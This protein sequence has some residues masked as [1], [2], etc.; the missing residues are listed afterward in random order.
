MEKADYDKAIQCLEFAIECRSAP[1]DN[2][3]QAKIDEC[4]RL[5]A[6]ADVLNGFVVKD[7]QF[8]AADS[9]GVLTGTYGDTLRAEDVKQLLIRLE[10]STEQPFR[11]DMTIDV[12]LSDPLGQLLG[13]SGGYTYSSPATITPLDS[14]ADLQPYGNASDTFG[15][16]R[17]RCEVWCRDSLFFET[18]FTLVPRAV[19][20]G[21]DES[22]NHTPVTPSVADETSLTTPVAPPADRK[23]MAELL[24]VRASAGLGLVM[25]SFAC[26]QGGLG[27]GLDIHVGS[28]FTVGPYAELAGT[29]SLLQGG[30]PYGSVGLEGRVYFSPSYPSLYVDVQGGMAFGEI[31]RATVLQP[32]WKQYVGHTQTNVVQTQG[33]MFG[34][35]MGYRFGTTALG[36]LGRVLPSHVQTS[37]EGHNQKLEAVV[38]ST[39]QFTLAF[40]VFF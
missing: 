34:A 9:Q 22:A 27:V 7:L 13:G 19:V 18:F 1:K 4:K 8:A 37:F 11:D 21:T 35:G 17:Y 5:K 33:L 2:D 15:P 16:G 29:Q 39:Y 28:L 30:K 14:L 31:V 36:L 23:S 24:E 26:A 10:Y 12:K 6:I 3:A 38:P 25:G 20:D 32:Q 40:T